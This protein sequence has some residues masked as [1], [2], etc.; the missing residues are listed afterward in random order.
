MIN[1]IVIL[2]AHLLSWNMNA[3][4]NRSLCKVLRKY[5]H[6]FIKIGF[7]NE[8]SKAE[9]RAQCAERRLMLAKEA[10]K[11]TKISSRNGISKPSIQS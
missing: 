2:S 8:G 9:P 4:S 10:L 11:P 3:I 5:N 1:I 7:V 6:D